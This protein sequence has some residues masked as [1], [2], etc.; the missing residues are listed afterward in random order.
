MRLAR[1]EVIRQ[2]VHVHRRPPLA[3]LARGIDGPDPMLL[4]AQGQRQ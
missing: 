2:A 3:I 1:G 4:S